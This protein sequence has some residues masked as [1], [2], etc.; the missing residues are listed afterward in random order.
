MDM[1]VRASTARGGLNSNNV[2][3]LVLVDP[4]IVTRHLFDARDGKGLVEV[5]LPSDFF[6]GGYEDFMDSHPL[7]T[8][9]DD[10]RANEFEPFRHGLMEDLTYYWSTKLPECFDSKQPSL[11]SVSYY[12]LKIIAAEWV[13]YLALMHRS[14]KQY[15]YSN[16]NDAQNFLGDL[17]KLNSDMRALQIWRRRSMSSQ[18]KLQAVNRLLR[19]S[20]TSYSHSEEYRLL[21]EDYDYLS[22]NMDEFGRRL[23]RML[24]VVTSL[25]QIVD[26]RRSFAETA[27][28]SRLTI[29]ALVFVPLTFVASLFSMS[30]DKGPGGHYFWVYFVVALPVTLVVYLIARPPMKI[31]SLTNW[32]RRR[33][34]LSTSI[35]TVDPFIVQSEK[36]EV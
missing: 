15:E 21:V 2:L 6:L 5:N 14:I 35:E 16:R 30:P 3:G 29:L 9:D 12:P 33:R 19:Y 24:P 11:M 18:Q 34:K 7:D 28:I 10:D 31:L 4:P 32:S 27:N 25:V 26:S 23:E 36:P 22:L 20:A 17:E 8:D 1:Y 13:K